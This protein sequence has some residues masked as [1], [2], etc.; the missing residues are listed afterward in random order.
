MVANNLECVPHTYP[1]NAYTLRQKGFFRICWI[2]KGSALCS[3]VPHKTFK[4]ASRGQAK[5]F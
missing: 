5:T 2:I 3:K 4:D 1:V